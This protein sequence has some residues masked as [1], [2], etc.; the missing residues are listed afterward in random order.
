MDLSAAPYIHMKRVRK[1]WKLCSAFK[2]QHMNW[3]S[4][5]A[6]GKFKINKNV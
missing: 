1:D 6:Q 5:M 2:G 4:N 3:K